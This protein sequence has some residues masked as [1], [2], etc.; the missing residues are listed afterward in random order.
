MEPST[1]VECRS[2]VTQI[3]DLTV[4]LYVP[5]PL[6]YYSKY[7]DRTENLFEIYVGNIYFGVLWTKELWVSENVDLH[8]LMSLSHILSLFICPWRA[9]ACKPLNP[10]SKIRTK[11]VFWVEIFARGVISNTYENQHLFCSIKSCSRK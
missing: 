1:A 3:W 6:I 4:T 10:C 9:I 8:A 11:L 5:L 7:C 2:H